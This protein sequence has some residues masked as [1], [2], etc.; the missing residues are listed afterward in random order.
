[1]FPHIDDVELQG[2]TAGVATKLDVMTEVEYP[3]IEFF[4]FVMPEDLGRED[5]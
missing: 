2:M 4:T 1:M 3:E 5:L